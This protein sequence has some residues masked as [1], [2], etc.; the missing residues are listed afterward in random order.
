M[1]ADFFFPVVAYVVSLL[2]LTFTAAAAH[3]VRGWRSEKR[4]AP[5]VILRFEQ[6]ATTPEPL[7]ENQRAA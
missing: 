1:W 4:T 6:R 3:R 2:V 5:G 7:A